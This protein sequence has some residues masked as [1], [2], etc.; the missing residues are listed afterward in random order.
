M[1]TDARTATIFDT[2]FTMKRKM[3]EK[4]LTRARAKCPLPFCAGTI[5]A[6]LNGPKK[7]I[8]GACDQE[9]CHL[10]FAE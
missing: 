8:S 5:L 7:S 9:G 2:M 6:T 3:L 1:N 10:R 4:G